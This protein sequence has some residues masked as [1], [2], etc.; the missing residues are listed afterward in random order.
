MSEH[1]PGPW[2]ELPDFA[3]GNDSIT[4]VSKKANRYVALAGFQD[5]CQHKANARLIAAAPE[6][7]EALQ[8][9]TDC[10][11]VGYKNADDLARALSSYMTDAR[12]LLAK[13]TP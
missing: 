2:I 8:R 10:Y 6:M 9:I 4:I 1:T 3:T 12:A 11:G 13:A 5:E 7:F